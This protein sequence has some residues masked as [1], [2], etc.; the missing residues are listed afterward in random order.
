MKTEHYDSPYQ[1]VVDYEFLMWMQAEAEYEQLEQGEC[2]TE[3]EY[4]D[5]GVDSGLILC[6][7]V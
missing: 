6:I 4:C 1:G 5:E 3:E 2:P 7:R